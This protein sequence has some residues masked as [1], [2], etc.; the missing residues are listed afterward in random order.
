MDPPGTQRMGPDCLDQRF[1]RHHAGPDPIRQRRDIDLA[2]FAG[3][4]LAM[5]G[6]RGSSRNLLTTTIANRLEPAK[7]RGIGWEA[8]GASVTAS[9]SRQESFLRT[10]HLI[11]RS[12]RL[13]LQGSEVLHELSCSSL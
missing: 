10:R 1:Q 12:Q 5:P 9:Q 2:T 13:L 8:A 7:P 6:Q 3:K 11:V 4:G